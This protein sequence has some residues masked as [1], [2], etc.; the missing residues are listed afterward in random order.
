[1][2]ATSTFPSQRR[3]PQ[4]SQLVRQPARQPLHELP[5]RL[6]AVMILGTVCQAP[7]TLRHRQPVP[8][9][10]KYLKPGWPASLPAAGAV[11]AVR[12]S[13]ASPAV[14]ARVQAEASPGVPARVQ[15]CAWPIPRACCG[16]I[17]GGAVINVGPN[18]YVC[19]VGRQA[20][21]AAPC[22]LSRQPCRRTSTPSCSSF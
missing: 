10:L 5:V 9:V 21:P 13:S 8:W 18:E 15:V 1:M 2:P 3:S 7:G 16:I 22:R 14:K 17:G 19:S 12:P 20:S 6:H 4:P 11:H